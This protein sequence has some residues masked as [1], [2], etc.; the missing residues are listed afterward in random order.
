VSHFNWKRWLVI[1]KVIVARG[2][3]WANTPMIGV[4]FVSAVRMA[5]PTLVDRWWK[6]LAFTVM[7]LVGIYVIGWFDK[8]LRLFH[9]ENN[10]MVEV[11]PYV[12]EHIKEA[13]RE[14]S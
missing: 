10:Y 4:I 12:E 9:E 7:G 6:F 13:K 11:S 1:Q 8:K 2:Y 14:E 5:F 3:Q